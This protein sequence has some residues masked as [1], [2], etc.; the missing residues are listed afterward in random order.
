MNDS[1]RNSL[2]EIIDK[3]LAEMA[4]GL[5]AATVGLAAAR[6]AA[7]D[8]RVEYEDEVDLSEY[9]SAFRLVEGGGDGAA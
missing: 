7:G 8:E 1:E 5:D 4:R 2:Q 9:D 6:L 3:A